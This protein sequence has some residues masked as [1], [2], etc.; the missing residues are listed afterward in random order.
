MFKLNRKIIFGF[1]GFALALLFVWSRIH[2]VELGYIVSG[3]KEESVQMERE[4]GLLKSNLAK[5]LT[6]AELVEFANKVGMSSP[7]PEQIIYLDKK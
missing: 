5:Q 1:V 7:K 4:I 6:T 3:L 2:V